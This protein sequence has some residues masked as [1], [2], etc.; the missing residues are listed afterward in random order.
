MLSGIILMNFMKPGVAR[1][2][3][4]TWFINSPDGFQEMRGDPAPAAISPQAVDTEAGRRLW[5]ACETLT[6]VSMLSA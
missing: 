5:E 2:F 4:T 1:L 3:A 6:G